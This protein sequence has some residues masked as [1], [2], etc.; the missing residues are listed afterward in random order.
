MRIQGFFLWVSMW[1]LRLVGVGRLSPQMSLVLAL[2]TGRVVESLLAVETWR[3]APLQKFIWLFNACTDL[4]VES[5]FEHV[6]CKSW[7]VKQLYIH[8]I[9]QIYLR[10]QNTFRTSRKRQGGR[11]APV[12]TISF[13]SFCFTWSKVSFHTRLFEEF[14]AEFAGNFLKE[15]KWW[16][17]LLCTKKFTI[18]LYL[19]F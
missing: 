8:V 14:V 1:T 3:L 7:I 9:F 15:Q 13:C 12:G 2:L 17:S 6:S 11:Q 4:N 16:L 18:L 5:H 19:Q 10:H